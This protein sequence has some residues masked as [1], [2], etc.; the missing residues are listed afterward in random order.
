MISQIDQKAELRKRRGETT[1]VDDLTFSEFSDKDL[2]R[3]LKSPVP[4]ERTSAAKELGIRKYIPGVDNLC[5]TLRKEKKLYT[6]IAISEA[7]VNIGVPSIE[8]LCDLLGEIGNNQ[9]R[10]LPVKGFYK[11]SYPLPRDIAARTLI[12]MKL[13]TLPFL[14][15]ALENNKREQIS[16]AIDAIGFISFYEKNNDAVPYLMDLYNSNDDLIKW[17]VVRAF[18]SFGD[19]RVIDILE[20]VLGD[21]NL[22]AIRW[23]AARSLGQIG[24]IRCLKLLREKEKQEKNEFQK[25]I[26]F[27]MKKN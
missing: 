19:D 2:I 26:R 24:N 4:I 25:M 15:R 9:E 10:E 20:E 21:D 3:Y 11:R 23:E 27:I 1:A 12:R 17:K 13:P 6:K 16:E 7:L 22:P 5:I 14:F 18:Q 8:P